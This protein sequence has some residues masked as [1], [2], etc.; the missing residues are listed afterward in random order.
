[1]LDLNQVLRDIKGMLSRLIGEH[2]EITTIL[3]PHLWPVRA[4]PVQIEQIIINLAVNARDA[5]PRG[6]VL[7]IETANVSSPTGLG[8]TGA[9]PSQCI[10]LSVSDNGIGMSE[11]VEAHVFEPFFTTKQ[12]GTGLGLATVYS[13]VQ[14][15]GGSIRVHS[16]VGEGTT[17]EV[18]L[19]RVLGVSAGHDRQTGSEEMPESK[20]TVLLVEDEAGV[21][22]LVATALERGG[23]HVLQAGSAQEALDK[24]HSHAGPINLLLTD[25]IMPGMSGCE[26]AQRISE[27]CPEL[28]LLYMSGYPGSTISGLGRLDPNA[29]FIQKP[30][31]LTSLTHKVREVLDG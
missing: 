21:R 28:K 23:F 7:A 24:L 3:A 2:V 10:M 16:K 8:H 11:E 25:V 29:A 26:L 18:Y 22:G 27:V 9:N 31:S 4:D 5:M 13:I 12:N 15:C 20:E 14:E 1:M 19:P 17:L 6:G 30:F